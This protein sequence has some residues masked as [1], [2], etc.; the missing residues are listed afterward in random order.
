VYNIRPAH[1]CLTA[2]YTSH[3]DSKF[4]VKKDI[5]KFDPEAMSF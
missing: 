2:T 4:G 1:E 3:N 5:I